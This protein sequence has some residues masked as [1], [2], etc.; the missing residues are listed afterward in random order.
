MRSSLGAA[1]GV[2]WLAASA[3]SQETTRVS[4]D[5][6]G[7]EAN[8]KSVDIPSIS[9]DGRV[10]A[11]V[12]AASNLVPG[13]TNGML[14]VF[15]HDRY[16]G[17]TERISLDPH[18]GEAD[19]DSRFTS[20]S[21]DGNFV[22][23]SSY[24]TNLVAGD[25]NGWGDVFVYDR[26]AGTTE[27]V[28]VGPRGVQANGDSIESV[29]SISADGQVVAFVSNATNLAGNASGNYALFTR[30]RSAGTT[31]I[32]SVDS[33]GVESIGQCVLPGLSADG[34]LVTFTSSAWDLVVG[35][36]NGS[37]DI[38][39]H[40]RWTGTTERASVDSS[41]AEGNSVSW[42]STISWDGR[43]VA[44]PSQSTNLVAG[45]TNGLMDV[46]VHDR[47]TGSTERVSVDSSGAEANW[48]SYY[49]WISGD[50]QTVAF[51]SSAS[52][53]VAGDTNGR[54]DF[55]V[56][57]RL[58]G[59]TERESVD[60]SGNEGDDHCDWGGAISADGRYVVIMSDATNLVSG[61]TNSVRDVF[62]HERCDSVASSTNYG[63]GYAGTNG[64][65]SI[66]VPS[67]PVLG[68]TLQLDVGNSY[69]KPTA[70]LLFVG[71]Q[72]AS[73]HSSLGGDLL[74]IPAFSTPIAVPKDG[75]SLISTLPQDA[76]FCGFVIDLQALESDPGAKKG[77]SFT[78]GLELLLGH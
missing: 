17:V 13:D 23:Y 9:A 8:D 33:N 73:I 10:V 18:G 14:D 65:P 72:R 52:N 25:T 68:T 4:V 44:F 70:A 34:R 15:V 62:V 39:V 46:F 47:V 32:V 2:A 16:T 53:L 42:F 5:T 21:A 19:G 51:L 45:D 75:A 50:G 64:V 37:H 24:A 40:D 22:A 36:T 41:G 67:A 55:F 60:S 69:G 49:A 38:F 7:V 20:I 56:H 35:D 12:S 11:F 71:Y 6:G 48:S 61:D 66:T 74:L 31:D 30:D 3:E 78:P 29:P 1:L 26:A 27:R 28:S 59:R 43:F 76:Q 77:V 54:D 57:D 58:T 63:A